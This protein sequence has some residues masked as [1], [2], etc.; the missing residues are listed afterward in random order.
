MDQ[1]QSKILIV[2][3][4]E[5]IR[6]LV[7]DTVSTHHLTD[8]KSILMAENGLHALDLIKQEHPDIIITDMKMPKMNGVQMLETLA[9]EH[10]QSTN[11]VMSGYADF[12]MAVS[13]F[14]L[15]V[16]SLLRKPFRAEELIAAIERAKYKI[17]LEQDNMQYMKSLAQAEKFSSI[18]MLAAGVAHEINNPNTFVKGN[19]ELIQ[20][21]LQVLKPLLIKKEPLDPTEQKKLS[22]IIEQLDPTIDAAINGSERIRRIVVSFLSFSRSSKEQK[23]VSVSHII[24]EASTLTLHKNKGHAIQQTYQDELPKIYVNEQEIVQVFMNLLINAIDAITDNGTDTSKKGIL[25]IQAKSFHENEVCIEFSDNGPGMTQEALAQ[26]FVPFFT[27]KPSGKGTGLGLSISKA[28]VENNGGKMSCTSAPGQ[29]T[30]F[31]ITLPTLKGSKNK[32]SFKD[33]T[34]QDKPS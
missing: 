14:N 4:E 9:H 30:K 33:K 15:N 10:C 24:S 16:F 6:E 21:Y 19:L 22:L 32:A 12:E 23:E 3:D 18:G 20:K 1:K 28:N 17:K 31:T 7:A 8:D 26:I 2:D 29:G 11:I 5:I 27:T 34:K 25:S 13:L